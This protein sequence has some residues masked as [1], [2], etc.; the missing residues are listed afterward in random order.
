[1]AEE[2]ETESEGPK[3]WKEPLLDYRDRMASDVHGNE[4]R[5]KIGACEA[6]KDVAVREP[7][8]PNPNQRNQA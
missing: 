2:A 5:H 8:L 1:M 4:A 6:C 7:I 3:E